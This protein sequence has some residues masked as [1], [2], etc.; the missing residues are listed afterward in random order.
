M[1][2]SDDI[3]YIHRVRYFDMEKDL[4]SILGGDIFLGIVGNF[5]F[6]VDFFKETVANLQLSLF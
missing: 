1:D 2:D 6:L 3:L 4:D 5:N